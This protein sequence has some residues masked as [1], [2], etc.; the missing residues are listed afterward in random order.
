M[1][2]S[3]IIPFQPLVRLH[4]CLLSIGLR[5]FMDEKGLGRRV[6]P[7]FESFFVFVSIR[8]ICILLRFG[9]F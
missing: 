7:L 6:L 2:T 1:P 9:L 8:C 4:R 5:D 3:L